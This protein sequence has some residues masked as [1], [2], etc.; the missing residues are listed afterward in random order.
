MDHSGF[1]SYSFLIE[2]D[3]KKLIYSGDFRQHGR[4]KYALPQ[5]INKDTKKPDALLLEGTMLGRESDQTITE[6]DITDKTIE[7]SKSSQGLIFLYFSSQNIDRLVSFYKAAMSMNKVF[8]I[9][10]YTAYILS[11]LKKFGKIPHPSKSYKNI[12]IFFGVNYLDKLPDE[13]KEQFMHDM[14][15]F[16]ISHN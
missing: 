12:R 14:G 5:F 11:K 9:D 8:V 13:E 6:D 1:D 4:K 7:I 15:P 3:G 10:V 16:K 2:A